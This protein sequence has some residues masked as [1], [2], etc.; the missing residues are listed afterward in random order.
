MFIT[1]CF[2]LAGLE[3]PDGELL[4][5]EKV[6]YMTTSSAYVMNNVTRM[7]EDIILWSDIEEDCAAACHEKITCAGFLHNP[8]IGGCQM[9]HE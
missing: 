1:N 5:F 9:W 6:E 4:V 2:F 3:K 7:L 8:I